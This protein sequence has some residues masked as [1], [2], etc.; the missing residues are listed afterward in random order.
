MFMGH[1]VSSVNYL[2]LSFACFSIEL[3]FLIPVYCRCSVPIQD[4]NSLS[5][6]DDLNISSALMLFFSPQY[7]FFVVK[8]II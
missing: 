3:P 1:A 8:Y 7:F 5:V 4:L 2:F 6:V